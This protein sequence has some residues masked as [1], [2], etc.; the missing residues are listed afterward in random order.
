MA[1]KIPYMI[2]VKNLHGI[3]TKIQRA[4]VPK[5]FNLDFLRDLGFKS[6]SDRGIIRL[7]K[8]LA[9]LDDTGVPQTPYREFMDDTKGKKVLANQLR[10]AYGDLF[11]SNP[12]AHKAKTGVLKGWFKTKTGEAEA[13]A[14]KIATTFRH[15]AM[16]ADFD[17]ISS[18][19]EV[20][21]DSQEELSSV[22]GQ[23]A[24][25]AGQ[26]GRGGK[27]ESATE[28]STQTETDLTLTYRLE[29][30]LPN[31]TDVRV[32]RA[33]FRALREELVS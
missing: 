9:M 21:A 22:A 3:L 32:F 13:V 6:S 26:A 24:S 33:I 11:L 16:Y 30:N 2:S 4:G 29:I 15:L 23:A 10:H 27:E 8:Y 12:D 1:S 5:T 28:K 17:A 7:L 14:T 20:C 31:T 19:S 18:T 25:V